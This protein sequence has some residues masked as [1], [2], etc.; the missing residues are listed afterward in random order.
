MLQN[1][2]WFAI[3]ETTQVIVPDLPFFHDIHK[4]TVW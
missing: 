3:V 4:Y 2:I 1:L